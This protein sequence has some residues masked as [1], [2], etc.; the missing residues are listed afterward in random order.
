MR[1]RILNFLGIGIVYFAA[2]MFFAQTLLAAYLA[3]VWNVDRSKIEQMIATAQGYDLYAME[4]ERQQ[5]HIDRV[6]QALYDEVLQ[7]RAERLLQGDLDRAR[8][9]VLE[10]SVLVQVRQFEDQRRQFDEIVRNFNRRIADVE[11][12]RRSAAFNDLVSNMSLLAPANA[13]TQIMKMVEDKREDQVVSI[14]G[15]MEDGPRKKLLNVMREEEEIEVLADILRRIAD[16][17]PEAQIAR[18]TR[19]ELSR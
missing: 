16:G 14:L 18:D 7:L 1:D 4:Q 15:A 5:E 12:A 19:D 17:E 13:K 6:Q 11:N 10:D 8:G 3:F 2:S 9:G